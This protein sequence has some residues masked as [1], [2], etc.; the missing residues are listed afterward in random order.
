[1]K[2]KRHTVVRWLVHWQSWK[3]A[4]LR[5]KSRRFEFRVPLWNTM[6]LDLLSTLCLPRMEGWCSNT[7]QLP[8]LVQLSRVRAGRQAALTGH[9]WLPRDLKHSIQMLTRAP[10]VLPESRLTLLPWPHSP[11][12]PTQYSVYSHRPLPEDPRPPS[13]IRPQPECMGHPVPLCRPYLFFISCPQGQTFLRWPPPLPPHTLKPQPNSSPP[14]CPL[15]SSRKITLLLWLTK[16]H[17][18]PARIFKDPS[19]RPERSMYPNCFA[20]A[21]LLQDIRNALTDLAEE[22]L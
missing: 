21:P 18:I 22:T 8:S 1:M 11:R 10:T 9:P 14:S 16:G 6:N 12:D 17:M 4:E 19:R 20:K 3:E 15:P 5:F 2:K 7:L 13:C